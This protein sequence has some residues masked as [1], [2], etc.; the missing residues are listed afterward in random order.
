MCMFVLKIVLIVLVEC[1]CVCKHVHECEKICEK[2][3]VGLRA[4][5]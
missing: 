2:L 3:V 1:D 5:A 4:C